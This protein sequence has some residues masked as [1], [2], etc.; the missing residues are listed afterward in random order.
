MRQL[1]AQSLFILF[2]LLIFSC[3]NDTGTVTVNYLEATAIYGDMDAIRS[4][5]LNE[6]GC[7]SFLR[8]LVSVRVRLVFGVEWMASSC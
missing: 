3:T 1:Y 6:E 8:N 5:P 4:I 7:L 2:A